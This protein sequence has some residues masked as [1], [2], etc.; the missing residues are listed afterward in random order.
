VGPTE[1]LKG[2]ARLAG[3]TYRRAGEIYFGR[4]LA[5][6]RRLTKEGRVTYGTGTYGVPTI[7]TFI[8]DD[9]CL[10]VGNYSCIGSSIMLG[11][12]H[13]A[14]RVTTYPHRIM[15]GMDGAGHDGF[16][17]HTGD[18][19]I[20]SDVWTG[21]GSMILSGVHIGDGAL[22]AAGAMVHKDV[23]PY[24]VVGGNPA[25]IIKYRF[26]EEQIAA[27][28]EIR[29]WDW[30]EDAVRAAVP[31]LASKDIDEFIAYARATVPSLAAAQA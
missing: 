4:D 8:H 26:S 16:P 5:V 1:R 25:K 30:T 11:G 10:R 15:L 3:F 9:T 19:V 6:V 12:E 29:W 28:L 17:V 13:A 21:Y 27:L 23:P 20:G 2:A 22:V 14:D 18:T 7:H 24:A 31:L